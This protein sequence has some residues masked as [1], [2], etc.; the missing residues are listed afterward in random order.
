[1]NKLVLNNKARNHF[2]FFP[3][4][5]VFDLPESEKDQILWAES[6]YKKLERSDDAI[7]LYTTKHKTKG[8][9]ISVW[10]YESRYYLIQCIRNE[11]KTFNNTVYISYEK[12]DMLSIAKFL[13][14]NIDS[15]M[16]D[17]KNQII[18]LRNEL[19]KNEGTQHTKP[20]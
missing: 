19:I 20:N 14:N 3:M 16:S 1:M 8:Y 18:D 17:Y 4:K 11:F 5:D 13:K 9:M 10:E 15:I 2:K 12:Q 6:L 7:N